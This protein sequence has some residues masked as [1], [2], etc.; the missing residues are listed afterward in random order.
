MREVIFGAEEISFRDIKGVGSLYKVLKTQFAVVYIKWLNTSRSVLNT[1]HSNHFKK[2]TT[3]LF[4][5]YKTQKLD[6]DVIVY[7][8]SEVQRD[9]IEEKEKSF[10]YGLLNE[11]VFCEF[12]KLYGII[13][14]WTRS[15]Q[16]SEDDKETILRYLVSLLQCVDGVANSII[17]RADKTISIFN[18]TYQLN[19]VI[20]FDENGDALLLTDRLYV[21]NKIQYEY[22][23]IDGL[24]RKIITKE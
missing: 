12:S 23:S 4:S 19:D 6:L 9:I 14:E 5:L 22:V 17:N 2:I 13:Y 18:N 7:I 3:V 20:I 10:F 16:T 21:G 8:M 1:Y 24:Y 15:V 11:N